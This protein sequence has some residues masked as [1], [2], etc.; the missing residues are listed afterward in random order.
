MLFMPAINLFLYN[1]FLV[2]LTKDI[3]RIIE[4][5]TEFVSLWHQIPFIGRFVAPKQPKIEPPHEYNEFTTPI[6]C[7]NVVINTSLLL[8][9]FVQ[10]RHFSILVAIVLLWNFFIFER[11]FTFMITLMWSL[12][13]SNITG[14]YYLIIT[15][16]GFLMNSMHF[17]LILDVMKLQS[18][19]ICKET[20]NEVEVADENVDDIGGDGQ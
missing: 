9:A 14:F 2:Y 10:H 5:P 6:L 19:C 12:W 17:L 4:V 13:W 16:C 1:A 15:F 3:K 20:R 7:L 18:G 8:P 11:M